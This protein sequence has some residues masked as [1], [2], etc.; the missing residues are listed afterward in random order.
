MD[1]NQLLA[2]DAAV[3]A[4]ITQEALNEL[5]DYW[6][7]LDFTDIRRAK[8]ELQKFMPY[9]VDKYGHAAGAAAAD[10]YN[11]LRANA[12]V[13]RR[14]TAYT[15][16]ADLEAVSRATQRL[17]GSLF[18]DDLNKVLPGLA[19]VVNKQ[20]RG[21]GRNTIVENSQ[22]D[23]SASGWYRIAK[24]DACNF[25]VMLSQRGAVY[26]RDTSRFSA[27]HTCGCR[28][29]PSFDPNAKSVH[30][31]AYEASKRTSG[32]TPEQRD[33]H[34][35]AVRSW[36]GRNQKSIDAFRSESLPTHG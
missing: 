21:T 19:A 2:R 11:E 18:G 17:A 6:R 28:A 22:R 3:Q 34:N 8:W 7:S 29:A 33:R 30:P 27:H 32:M 5:R 4:E 35:Q 23:P 26:T 25:C 15:A 1:P 9:L 12:G 24:S 36:I 16:K 14:F 31:F 20:V 13:Q 10:L